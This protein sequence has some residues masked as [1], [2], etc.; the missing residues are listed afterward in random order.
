MS[1][2]SESTTEFKDAELLCEALRE[3]GYTPQLH[4]TAQ[5]L[6]GYQGDQR[7]ETA[8]II[9]PR[10]QV[11]N[12]ANDVGFKR[13]AN[14][15]YGAIISE[16]DGSVNCTPA[17]QKRLK[18]TY[19]EKAVMRQAKRGGLKFAGKETKNGKVQLKFVKA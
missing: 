8:E 13:N 18:S 1:K 19:A 6:T 17:W 7:A 5:H 11:G 3:L 4:Q 15:T 16:Y 9:I 14:G 12:S 10:A 2:Y